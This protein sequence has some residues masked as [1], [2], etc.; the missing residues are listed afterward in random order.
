MFGGNGKSC[1]WKI[2]DQITFAVESGLFEGVFTSEVVGI[3]PRQGLIQIQFPMVEGRLVLLPVGTTVT[4][5]QE[6]LPEPQN[7]FIVIERVG[8]EKRSLVLKH[9]DFEINRLVYLTP[10]KDRQLISV[11][12]GKGGAGKTTL[13]INLAYALAE[14]NYKTC[15]FD[16]ALG[17][18]NVDVLLDLAPRYHLGHLIAGK[19]G[20]MD[21]LTEVRPRMYVVPGCSG[22]QLLTELTIYEYNLLASEIQQLFDYFDVIIIDTSSGITASTTNFILASQGGY[23]ITTPEPHAITDTYALLKTLVTQRKRPVNLNLVVNRVYYRSEAKNTADK[24]QF[25]AR[26][27]LNFELGYAGFIFDDTRVREANMQQK[28]VLELEPSALAS[29]GLRAIADKFHEKDAG[30]RNRS[31]GSI[32]DRIKQISKRA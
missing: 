20:L 29:Q 25:A 4:I 17:T 24:L 3:N 16:A 5:R 26:K 27:F 15:I 9:T 32:L 31:P 8:G 7:R 28:P 2:G 21:I 18:A 30:V 13:A 6:G 1:N 19:R 11:C 14:W 10:P 22:V 23:L 12:S